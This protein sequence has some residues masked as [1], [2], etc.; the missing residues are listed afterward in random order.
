MFRGKRAARRDDAVL[1]ILIEGALGLLSAQTVDISRSGLL[2]RLDPELVGG[3]DS[4]LDLSRHVN[5][6]FGE[7]PRLI[8]RKN[9]E[10]CVALVRVT[11][12]GLGGSVV[13]LVACQFHT[14]LSRRQHRRLMNSE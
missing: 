5:T 4:L 14:P 8:L 11:W 12:G 10:R 7:S 2:F 1:P 3:G 6:Y 9:I 13:P